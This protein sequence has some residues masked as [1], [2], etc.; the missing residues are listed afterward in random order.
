VDGVEDAVTGQV[1]ARI[2]QVCNEAYNLNPVLRE[3][4]LQSD[5][6]KSLLQFTTFEEVLEEIYSKVTYATPF[7]P[8]TRTPSSCFC[9]LMKFFQMKL[10]YRQ[11]EVLLE[12]TDS[13]LIPV[14][15][16][17]YIRY[18]VDPKEMW[19]WYEPKM[20]DDTEFDPGASG[21]KETIGKFLRGIIEDIHYYDTI[22]PRIPVTIQRTMAENIMKLEFR[23]K[24]MAELRARIKVGSKVRAIYY[25][26]H[27]EYEAK[28][29]SETKHGTFQIVFTEYG[30]EQET[31]IEDM[32]IDSEDNKRDKSRSRSR[33][34]ER[35]KGSRRDRDR[36]RSRSR[37]RK[38]DR[39]RSR[40]RSKGRSSGPAEPIDW[41]KEVLKRQRDNAASKGG[42]YARRPTSY[43]S[44]LSCALATS[45]TRQRSPPRSDTRR[46]EERR[47]R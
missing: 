31:N 23:T 8:N 4:I 38:R 28:V 12:H 6:F 47:R 32:R 15:G 43:K 27:E 30:N 46:D 34:A 45:S 20:I 42:D 5:Y 21:K 14:M 18:V 11:L 39:S 7:I 26:D 9:L 17:L 25:E 22:L 16:L 41:S 37:E 1:S 2:P 29:L 36:K 24:A 35:D 13:P 3:N 19:S 40:S 10:T 33:S 44:S